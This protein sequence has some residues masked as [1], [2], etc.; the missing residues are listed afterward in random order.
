MALLAKYHVAR[1]S[2]RSLP[3]SVTPSGSLDS[4]SG[5][6]VGM[7][8]R[9]RRRCHVHLGDKA[10]NVFAGGSIPALPVVHAFTKGPTMKHVRWA[11]GIT[12]CATVLFGA[13]LSGQV[14]NP[15]AREPTGTVQQVYDGTLTPDMVVSTFRNIERLFPTRIVRKGSHVHSLPASDRQLTNI[16]FTSN[17]IQYDLYDYL[18]LNRVSGLLV[19]KNGGI[20]LETYQLGNT[21]QPRWVSMSIVKS[22]LSAL[23]GAAIKS[24]HIRS[25]DDPITRYAP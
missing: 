9:A 13:A 12:C 14:P 3:Q 25:I 18:A 21:Q 23:F 11:F 6:V 17:G 24:G 15:H 5:H 8:V 2:V 10:F 22:M 7:P 16:Q 1:R 19:L 4:R 20:A